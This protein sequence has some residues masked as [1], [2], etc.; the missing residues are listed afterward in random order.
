MRELTMNEMELISGG[1]YTFR[2][3]YDDGTWREYTI[4]NA[5]Y[6]NAQ[7][8]YHT[9]GRYLSGFA[10]QYAAMAY[11]MSVGNVTAAGGPIC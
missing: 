8:W 2:Y 11:I 9:V 6:I 10:G 4:T 7:L 3:E 1:D 5:Q